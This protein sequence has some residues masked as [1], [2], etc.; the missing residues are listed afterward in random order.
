MRV[1]G[2]VYTFSVIQRKNGEKPY[3][4]ISEYCERT[5]YRGSVVVFS[6]YVPAFVSM[7]MQLSKGLE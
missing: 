3:F 4:R 2:A 1:N 6:P 7:V 5:G